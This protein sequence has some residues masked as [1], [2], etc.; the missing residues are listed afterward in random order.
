MLGALLA[1]GHRR[2]QNEHSLMLVLFVVVCVR[3]EGS[4]TVIVGNAHAIA[5]NTT[6]L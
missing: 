5:V 6:A 1:D 4:R 3:R 2:K